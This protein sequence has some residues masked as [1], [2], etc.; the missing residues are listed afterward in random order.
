VSRFI[1]D[2][3]RVGVGGREENIDGTWIALIAM[4]E[5]D[6][7]RVPTSAEASLACIAALSAVEPP[8]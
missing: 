6:E 4:L 1:D 5:V 2:L 8:G 3:Q 7:S